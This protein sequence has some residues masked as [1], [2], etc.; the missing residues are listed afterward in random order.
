M[1]QIVCDD[2]Y[3]EL[4]PV[5]QNQSDTRSDNNAST[6]P[7]IIGETLSSV[8]ASKGIKK[9]RTKTQKAK[10]LRQVQIGSG[11]K[12]TT[13]KNKKKCATRKCVCRGKKRK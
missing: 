10:K 1:R 8:P 5:S 3:C 9:K 7:L 12:R 13:E 2:K 4:A 11:K 6:A